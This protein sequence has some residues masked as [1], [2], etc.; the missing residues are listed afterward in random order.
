VR[1]ADIRR[2]FLDFYAAREHRIIPSASL[3]PEDPTLLLTVAGMVPFK[4]YFLGEK[5]IEHP[6]AASCQKCVRTNDIEIV[7]RTARHMTLFEMLG[8]FSFGDYYKQDAIRWAWEL[9]TEVLGFDPQRIWVTVFDDDDEAAEIWRD[10]VGLAEKRIVR[11]GADDNFWWMGVAGPAGPCSELFF[12]RRPAG[13]GD[14]FDDGDGL[15]EFYNLVFT[16]SEVDETGRVVGALGTKNVDTG[17]G[18][19]RTA[20]LLQEVDS[21]YETDHIR[22]LVDLAERLA[23]RRYGSDERTDVSLRIMAEHARA[24]AFMIG[25]GILPSNEG[26]GYVLRRLL[27]RGVRHARILGVSE[28]VMSSLADAVVTQMGDIYPEL[29]AGRS[30]IT[31]VV[32]G[33]EEGFL[34]TLRQ[35]LTLLEAGMEDARTEG[36]LQGATAF[37]LHDTYGFP[38]ELTSEIAAE[39]GLEIDREGFDRLMTEQRE[40]ARA[41]RDAGSARGDAGYRDVLSSAGATRFT[42]YD[43]TRD[44]ATIRGIVSGG[45]RTARASEGDEVDVVLDRTPFYPEGGGQVG[46]RGIIETTGARLEVLDTTRILGDLIV[47]RARVTAGEIADANPVTATVND[48]H[49]IAT[50][51][52]HTATH[53]VHATLRERLGE[54]ARQAGSL[55]EPG[56]LRFDFSHFEKVPAEVIDEIERTVNERIATDSP[57]QP[58]ETSMTEARRLGAM[59]LFE[60]KYGDI[61]R[62][63]EIGGYSIELCGGIHA[64]RTSQV[65]AVKLLGEASIGSNLRRIEALT[66][67]DAIAGFRRSDALLEHI[68][69]LLRTS[70][71]EAPARIEK[72]LGDLKHAEHELRKHASSGAA[73]HA[74]EIAGAATRIGDISSV[75]ASVDGLDAGGL[76]Q[77]AL[78]VRDRLGPNAVVALA[79]AADGRASIVCAIGSAIKERG[80]QPAA[81]IKEAAAAIGGGAGGRDLLA[82][83]GGKQVDGIP[84]ALDRARDAIR[85]AFGTAEGAA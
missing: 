6:R 77:L 85:A 17:M 48:A 36:R 82:T 70:P 2:A 27:R 44:E 74:K 53:V 20:V 34:S 25:D 83:G 10:E 54:H 80:A 39:A 65:G 49:R 57:V 58:Y 46:D 26:R 84:A 18:L 40:R 33:E 14:T 32:H 1:A 9:S 8:N 23:G 56:R 67:R 59:M 15:M 78:V 75:V 69:T 64:T 61:V 7:G 72:L 19:D 42:G 16:E 5:P 62:V 22:P 28:P 51:R 3:I 81:L 79:S 63:V 31:Q 12:D 73:E 13:E 43:R 21:V 71:D 76:Q 29:T 52:S 38:L 50:E 11:R 41:A 68:A 47:H 37:K 35:G 55:V 45:E 24:A 60:E 66:G 30:F 4:P